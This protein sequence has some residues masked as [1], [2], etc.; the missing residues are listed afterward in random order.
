MHERLSQPIGR[1]KRYV[2]A[3]WGRYILMGLWPCKP[4]RDSPLLLASK[5][6]VMRNS[7]YKLYWFQISEYTNSLNPC[8]LNIVFILAVKDQS[9]VM[10]SDTKSIC[11]CLSFLNFYVMDMFFYV[12]VH[13]LY[14]SLH[15]QRKAFYCLFPPWLCMNFY[16]VAKTRKFLW[17]FCVTILGSG[18]QI[19]RGGDN[20]N[21]L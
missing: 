16:I 8:G 4:H 11:S 17:F 3:F 21:I 10:V 2:W 19:N 14:M 15:G 6:S 18:F 20:H 1:G 7:E 5:L 13:W 12:K 9:D